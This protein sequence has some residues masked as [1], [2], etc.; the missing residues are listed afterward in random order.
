MKRER[1]SNT[2]PDNQITQVQL[3]YDLLKCLMVSVLVKSSRESL[4]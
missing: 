3:E 2:Q 4:N 1:R